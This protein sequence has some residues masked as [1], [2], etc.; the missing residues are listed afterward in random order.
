MNLFFNK[1]EKP[2][3]E[4]KYNGGINV[5]TRDL[6]FKD[7]H[8]ITEKDRGTRKDEKELCAIE[9]FT[10][11]VGE[12][13]TYI[14]KKKILKLIYNINLDKIIFNEKTGFYELWEK[15]KVIIFDKA[16][17][18]FSRGE[19]VNELESRKRY[20]KCHLRS[21]QLSPAIKGANILTGYATIGKEK[22]L[23]SVIEFEKENQTY[24]MDYTRNFITLKE[25]YIKIMNFK[26][27]ASVPA[28]YVV[29]DI[30]RICKPLEIEKNLPFYLIFRNEIMRDIERKNPYFFKPI[31]EGDVLK[32]FG[33]Y[34]ENKRNSED[35]NNY[36]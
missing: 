16:S 11:Q 22:F 27:L 32:D 20:G 14:F 29:D 15:D 18:Y 24:I 30:K 3:N 12:G 8:N 25:K 2:E 26:Q 23:H 28:E 33:L 4:G 9:F 13:V 36:R 5:K 19:I 7:Y 6:I 34:K 1:K 10:R 35:I 21:I 31:G 17:N